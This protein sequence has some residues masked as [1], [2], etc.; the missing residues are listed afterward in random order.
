MPYRSEKILIAG[1][2]HDSRRKLSKEQKQAIVILKREGYSYRKLAEMF[3][4]SKWTV[5]SIIR[6]PSRHKA[7]KLSAEYWAQAKKKFRKRKQQLCDNGVI[8]HKSKKNIKIK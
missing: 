1:T 7:K 5:Q 6:P 4:V 8:E 3:G 2:K